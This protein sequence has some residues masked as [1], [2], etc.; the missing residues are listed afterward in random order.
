MNEK[1]RFGILSFAHYHAN[2]WAE[3]I[4]A[5]PH[6]ELVGIWDDQPARGQEAAGRH[7]VPFE[8]E[9]GAILSA[10]DAVGITSET[11]KHAGLVEAAAAAGVNVL[12]EKPMATSLVE[13]ERIGKAIRDSGI[14]FMQNF[15]KRYDPVNQEL[16]SRV[17]VGELGKILAVRIRHAN[18][19]W[20]QLGNRAV[21]NWFT[22]PVLSG[23]GA[24]LDEGVHAADFLLWLLGEPQTTFALTSRAALGLPQED[25]AI[26]VYQYP[27]GTLAEIVT[28][29]AL[30][31]AQ[32][33]VEVYGTNGA[34]L[35]SGVDLA[36]KELSQAPFLKFYKRGAPRTGWQGSDIRPKFQGPDFH[37]G[38]PH[39]FIECLRD[40]RE[41]IVRFEDGWKSL[42]MV[43]AS[44][45][46]AQ[47]GQ[48]QE[49][50]FSTLGRAGLGKAIEG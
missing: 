19:H 3:A 43:L 18:Y 49:L 42:A 14:K 1:I 41:P 50:D 5:S 34:A 8:P 27:D 23:G 6:A 16:V 13:C 15:P 7:G 33:S 47:S 45:E 20:L 21:G 17:K 9:L 2:F 24:L 4:H 12:L 48:L 38:G 44:Y 29:N 37:Y 22:D 28:S 36:S 31:A 25:T 32:E 11:A 46:A 39:F 10:C 26:A 40:G 30:L 35:L